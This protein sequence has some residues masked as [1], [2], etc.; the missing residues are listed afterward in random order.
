MELKIKL[1]RERA[2]FTQEQ[3]AEKMELSQSAYARFE[4]SKT[5]IDLK[6]LER[7]AKELNRSLIEVLTF[8]DRYIN[9]VDIGKELNSYTPDVTVQ[10]K[11]AGEKRDTI[12]KTIF[13]DKDLE[14]LNK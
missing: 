1:L 12:L 5:K 2:G 3:M 7:F 8:P 6:R 14:I 9:V 13:G 11:V 4:L 10:I